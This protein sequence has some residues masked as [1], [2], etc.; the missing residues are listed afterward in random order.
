MDKEELTYLCIDRYTE[1]E[2]E[3]RIL[4]EKM[5]NIMSASNKTATQGA[6]VTAATIPVKMVINSTTSTIMQKR[7]L[8][9]EIRKRELLKITME[10]QTILKRL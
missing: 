7:S 9:K 10:N 6:S 8:N 2:R 4:L 3:N 1:I 5:T